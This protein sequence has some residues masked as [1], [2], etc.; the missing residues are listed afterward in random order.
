MDNTNGQQPHAFQT[1]AS[2][3]GDF[4]D[5]I[6]LVLFKVRARERVQNAF[7][8]RDYSAV[9]IMTGHCDS[10]C[11]RC[12]KEGRQFRLYLVDNLVVISPIDRGD[13]T[14]HT[15]ALVKVFE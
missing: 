12:H 7:L 6:A 2:D 8:D 10:Y 1:N 3:K 15:I 4:G 9:K 11:G 13:V 14:P 5:S